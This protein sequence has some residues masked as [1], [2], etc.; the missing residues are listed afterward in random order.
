MCHTVKT[1]RDGK[2]IMVSRNG[3]FNVS[4]RDSR[5]EWVRKLNQVSWKEADDFMKLHP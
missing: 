4:Q 3:R 5:G 1:S 2:T